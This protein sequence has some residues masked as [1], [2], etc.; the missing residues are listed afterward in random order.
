MHTLRLISV[1]LLVHGNELLMMKRSLSRTLS[2]GMWAG[3]GGHL[4]P[5]EIADPRSACLREIEEET[6]LQPSDITGL[7][8]RYILLRLNGNDLRQQFFYVGRA[9]RKDVGETE[10]GELHWIH[11]DQILQ[12]E[13]PF[14]FR[15]LLTH[16]LEHGEEDGLWSGTAT[17]E[18]QDGRAAPA[19]AVIWTP[20]ADP[21]LR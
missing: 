13:L 19:P 15:S 18:E 20:I 14:V 16:W 11:R 1:A 5:E 6:G 4:E 21:L 8:L 9:L 12:L 2:P 10:E 7:T 3:I 17:L